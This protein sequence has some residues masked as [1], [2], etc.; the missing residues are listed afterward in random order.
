MPNAFRW[1]LVWLAAIVVVIGLYTHSWNKMMATYLL[2][3]LGIMGVLLPDWDFFDRPF[4]HWNSPISSVD[5]HR[6][7][8]AAP[9]SAPTPKPPTR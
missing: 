9:N 3:M 8:I 6:D 1:A 7:G 2:G 4:S 5:H